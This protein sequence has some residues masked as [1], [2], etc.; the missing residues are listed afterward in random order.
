M[1]ASPPQWEQTAVPL[2]FRGFFGTD[3]AS[4]GEDP[5]AVSGR[6]HV[7]DISA[8]FPQCSHLQICFVVICVIGCFLSCRFFFQKR[9]GSRKS[10]ISEWYPF[11]IVRFT[12]EVT[13]HR[14][15]GKKHGSI[16]RQCPVV[17]RNPYHPPK[18]GS[19]D[20]PPNRPGCQSRLRASVSVWVISCRDGE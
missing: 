15:Q 16:I 8:S 10:F 20:D 11:P 6:V 5:A 1:S 2:S 7:T 18:R 4:D 17:W 12:I 19:R 13:E 3:E 14:C 9:S